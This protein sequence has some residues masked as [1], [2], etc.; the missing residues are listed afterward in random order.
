MEGTRLNGAIKLFSTLIIFVFIA[1]IFAQAQKKFTLDELD[2]PVVA[3][4]T[5]ETGRPVYFRGEATPQ[6]L[7]LYHPPLYIYALA[8]QIKVLVFRKTR[9]AHSD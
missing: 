5:S 2:F 6:H 8:A 4:A 1:L 9:F 3:K 7:G